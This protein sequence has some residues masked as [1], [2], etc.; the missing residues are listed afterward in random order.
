V[1]NRWT[2]FAIIILALAG[3]LFLLTRTNKSNVKFSDTGSFRLPGM[4]EAEDTEGTEDL[5]SSDS[6]DDIPP[7]KP[8]QNPPK[9]IK[10]I[11]ATSW[12]ASGETRMNDL[13]DL[14]K[15]TE[16]NAIVI[17]IKDYSGLVAYDIENED[18]K[19]YNAKEIRIL[20]PNALIKRLH[21]EGIYVIARQTVFQ[22]PI[23]AEARP[24]LAV[25]DTR[26]GKIW[27]DNKGISWVDPASKEVWD[28]NIAIAKD[29]ANRG[30]DEINFDYIR[31]PSDGN[32]DAMQ[33]PI[34][35]IN[36]QFKKE[37]VRD[38]F[39]YLRE[40]T[41]GIVISADLFGLSTVNDGDLGIGQTIEDAYRNFNYVSPMVYPSHYAQG[42]IGYSNPAAYPYEV[43][44]YS[45][46]SAVVRLNNLVSTSTPAS[47]LAQLRPWLQDFDLGADYT[48][49]MVLKEMQAV[50]DAGITN[51][52]MLWDPRNE[53]T[54]SALKLES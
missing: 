26:T 18:V 40:N 35:N 37:I 38:F 1:K 17:D 51:G 23:L 48:A 50:Y 41:K 54:R 43:I 24:D 53:Y 15:R 3:L 6:T 22:D 39:S 36:T 34:Y 16:L 14:I 29:T 25:K 45:M 11:Y 2:I 47:S 27:E 5:L 33:F 32:L 7:Q 46:D 28:Y 52:W 12:T 10:A 8:L 13:I 30:F 21:D 9:V 4:P 19:K 42:F 49:A 31:F 20:R 44:K